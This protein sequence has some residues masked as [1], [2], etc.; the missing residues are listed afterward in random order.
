MFLLKS[1]LQDIVVTV[2]F[3][4]RNSLR[5]IYTKRKSISFFDLL[6][7]FNVEIKSDS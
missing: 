3:A 5:F 6:S 2:D 1:F 7:L 4:N